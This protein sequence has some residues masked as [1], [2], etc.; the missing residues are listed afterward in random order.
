MLN[1][2]CERGVGT[3][4]A[5]EHILGSWESLYNVFIDGK[6]GFDSLAFFVCEVGKLQHEYDRHKKSNKQPVNRI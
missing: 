4:Y 5:R 2:D 6:T 3:L 1:E